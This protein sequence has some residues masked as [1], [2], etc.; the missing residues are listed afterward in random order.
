MKRLFVCFLSLCGLWLSGL[1][2]AQDPD[3]D[4]PIDDSPID[5]ED[6]RY[7]TSYAPILKP[8]KEAVV[9]VHAASVVRFIRRQGMNPREE[10]LRRFFGL[11]AP[12]TAEPEVEERR[13]AEGVG[14]GVVVSADGY[15]VTNNHVIMG[16]DG[17]PADEILVQLND[18]RE[19]PA[20]LVG[21][22][23]RSDL[24]VLKVAAEA[25]PFLPVADSDQ[26]EVGDIVFAIGNPMGVGL[27]ITQGI[28]S[29]TGRDNMRILGQSGYE[30]FIQ[31]DAPINPGNSG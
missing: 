9:A 17:E 14:S 18:G 31:T 27:T 8:A 21:R 28:V 11:P 6:P 23:P 16:R 25:L 1:S 4:W 30:S 26:L 22:D 10:M 5:R 24:A 3:F 29:A 7:L 12:G 2:A 13:F 19:L 20:A 15:I